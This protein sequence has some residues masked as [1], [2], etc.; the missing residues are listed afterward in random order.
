MK[1]KIIRL[2]SALTVLALVFSLVACGGGGGGGKKGEAEAK[3]ESLMFTETDRSD[4]INWYGR[5]YHYEDTAEVAF[6]LG[7]SG[8]EVKFSGT[9]L[10][11][12]IKSSPSSKPEEV[13]GNTYLYVFTDGVSDYKNATRI[14]LNSDGNE[15]EVV[16]CENL[17]SGEHTVKVLKATEAKY[18]TARV[19]K[20]TCNGKFLNP[21]TRPE[22]KIELI[23]DS[24]MSGSE[25]MRADRNQD[26]G[27]TVNENALASYGYLG[28]GILA[29]WQ[30]MK[31]DVT[32]VS[33]SGLTVSGGNETKY[34]N[35]S[36]FYDNY[37][38]V[39]DAAWDF[40]EFV[41]DFVVVDLG[42]NDSLIGTSSAVIKSYY[43]DF[44]RH[45]RGK[46]P[47]A[48]IICCYGAMVTSVNSLVNEMV[49][50][51]GDDNVYTLNLPK[52]TAGGH[53]IESEH[54]SNGIRLAGFINST[55]FNSDED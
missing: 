21:P 42:T 28:A 40:T 1:V 22:L 29:N 2:L 25:C 47:N 5:C 18:G 6:N 23:G 46:Y 51:L 49:A 36:D 39:D 8:F 13:S 15:H 48:A 45:V 9:K 24:I 20:I 50:E 53:P 52:I 4:V 7:A 11:A 37:S 44:L 43:T 41:P 34:P 16:L 19:S 54:N 32:V 26:S 27:L 35:I 38:P 3:S 10:T 30:S 31:A 12:S 14:E 55:F 17:G 33:Q